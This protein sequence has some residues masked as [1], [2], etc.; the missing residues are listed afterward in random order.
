MKIDIKKIDEGRF[1]IRE[2]NNKEYVEQLAASLKVDGQW[3]PIIVRPKEDGRYEVIAGHYRLQ[4]AKKA[5]FKEIEATVRA[6][7][8][9]DADVL[10]LKTN[11]IRLDMTPREQG[12]ILSK[13]MEQYG[14][15]Q[16]EVAK[17][18]NVSHDWVS[19]RVRV[20]LELHDKVAKALD[21]GKINF[22]VA[23]VIAGVDVRRQPE[24][25]KI[26]IEKNITLNTDAWTLR[27]QFLNDTIYTIGYQGHDTTSFINILKENDI[28][29]VMDV[30]FSSESQYKPE[31]N[32]PILKRELDRNKIKYMHKP[33]YGVPY[34]IQDPY[35]DGA[36]GIDCIKQWYKWH[37]EKE[38]DFNEFI[39]VLKKSGKT[40]LMCMESH[41]KPTKNQ[42]Y[43][44]HRD[45]LA[46]LILEF[47]S[48]DNLL[49]FNKRIDL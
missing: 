37:I 17:R 16:R 7:S 31:F 38:A 18:L 42:T 5:G 48:K 26:M 45:F 22:N 46:D 30:R 14:W 34:L 40:A 29:L 4:A 47:K 2:E 39:E 33:V 25:L 23:A 28:E 11:L 24:F 9:E 27:R 15:S 36:F 19:Q 13:M 41:A 1:V 20:A 12:L 44:C 43:S 10:S 21:S 49:K 32:G 35:K 3:N 8:D 6:L